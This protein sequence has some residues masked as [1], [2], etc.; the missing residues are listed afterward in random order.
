MVD[1]PV[2]QSAALPSI[3]HL[4]SA[5]SDRHDEQSHRNG[6]ALASPSHFRFG[7]QSVFGQSGN[8]G[9]ISPPVSRRTSSEEHISIPPAR[10]SLPSIHEALGGR[11]PVLSYPG[12]PP[13]PPP[14]ALPTS[15]SSYFPHANPTA[16]SEAVKREHSLPS[17]LPAGQSQHNA[18]PPPPPSSTRISTL[19]GPSPMF[20]SQQPKI[21]SL[22]PI[23]TGNSPPNA[24]S[25]PNPSY[26]P[27]LQRPA[28]ESPPQS[29]PANATF[30]YSGYQSQYPYPPSSSSSVAGQGYAGPQTVMSAPA[31]YPGWTADAS[32]KRELK[33][34]KSHDHSVKRKLDHFELEA[35]L[36][37][38][39]SAS[40]QVFNASDH[41]L[42]RAKQAKTT[43]EPSTNVVSMNDVDGLSR[44]I[45]TI[46][47]AFA[48]LQEMVSA[49]HAELLEQQRE[50]QRQHPD[51]S[52][53]HNGYNTD[54]GN[55]M[56]NPSDPKQVKRRGRAAPPGRCHSCNR[57]ETPEWRRGPDGARTL[58]N[59]CG[60][61]YAKLTRKMGPNAKASISSSNLRPKGV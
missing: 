35:S 23:R 45:G 60:L 49:S 16:S 4:E 13:P 19:S 24:S 14:S 31:Q 43:G 22:Q 33:P 34:L 56:G 11:E 7:T 58:C 37:E 55:G 42:K 6:T 26:P 2:R 5:K 28:Y 51:M 25:R 10:Q 30:E 36:Y 57:A 38:L 18:P 40:Q 54:A 52:P 59:A 29:A 53:E 61:H 46:Q 21:P 3:S 15:S 50:M 8:S 9:L 12:P 27:P 41:Y 1:T 17:F 47:R 39:H 48:R 32:G 44:E 20:P